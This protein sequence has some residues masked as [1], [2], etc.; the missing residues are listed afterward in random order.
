VSGTW[1]RTA[2]KTGDGKWDLKTLSTKG[3]L[4]RYTAVAVDNVSGVHAAYL[5]YKNQDDLYYAVS[6]GEGWDIT[7]VDVEPNAGFFPDLAVDGQGHPHIVY[8]TVEGNY[9]GVD[10]TGNRYVV[11]DL[12]YATYDGVRWH[13]DTIDTFGNVGYWPSIRVDET[14]VPCV[15]YAG[16]HQ[17]KYAVH[18]DGA[19]T[20]QVVDQGD[21]VGAYTSLSLDTAG[22][23]WIAY[24][25]GRK[26]HLAHWTGNEWVSEVVDDSTSV[27]WHCAMEIDRAGTVHIVYD[28]WH[29]GGLRYARLRGPT[30]VP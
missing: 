20:I 2:R 19:W 1:V 29:G 5:D 8:A 11:D 18:L 6:N 23:P 15:S 10:F 28:D 24:N 4:G 7:A 17:I 25:R 14:G 13:T 30:Q 9:E 12:K 22:H 27:G 26:L 21:D 16:E 3:N